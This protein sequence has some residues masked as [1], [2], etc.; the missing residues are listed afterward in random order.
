MRAALSAIGQ[1]CRSC[2]EAGVAAEPALARAS[3]DEQERRLRVLLDEG[4]TATTDKAEGCRCGRTPNRR[5]RLPIRCRDAEV[6]RCWS[7]GIAC[8]RAPSDRVLRVAADTIVQSLSGDAD[9]LLDCYNE[10]V[11]Q[12]QAF[13]EAADGIRTHDLLHGK[14][15]M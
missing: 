4:S 1:E 12:M 5:G 3:D 10:K 7:L 13:P 2:A 9:A 14:Q 8:S 6:P 11:L 15:Y